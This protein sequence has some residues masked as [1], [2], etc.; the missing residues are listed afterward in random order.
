MRGTS[1]EPVDVPAP[2]P[3]S[4]V[5][6]VDDHPI[7][8]D[9]LADMLNRTDDFTVVGVAK[10]GETALKKLEGVSVD[11]LLSDLIMPGMAG[12][13]LL[14]ALRATRYG[15][16]V[17]MFSGVGT[18]NAIMEAY[19]Q[20]VS[21]F[22]EKSTGVE[23]LLSTLRAVAEGK[24]PLNSRMGGLMRDHVRRRKV[25]KPLAAGDMLILRRLSNGQSLKEIA[26]ELGISVSGVYK[27]RARIKARLNIKGT[28][29]FFHV[30]MS[31]G[32][33]S[34]SAAP[35]IQCAPGLDGRGVGSISS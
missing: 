33:V 22:V 25:F 2:K 4:R 17:V 5:F 32:L 23:E 21:A 27:A 6:I 7:L 14:E 8:S 35:A 1:V 24:F 26:G 20:G 16:K 31:L 9:V 28:A 12:L 19:S 3:R 29:G 30:A 18:D 13:E 34:P 11:I 10:D 15:L